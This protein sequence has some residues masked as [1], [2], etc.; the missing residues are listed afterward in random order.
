MEEKARRTPEAARTAQY[1][2][3]ENERKSTENPIIAKTATIADANDTTE[4][5]VKTKNP[6]TMVRSL[7]VSEYGASTPARSFEYAYCPAS[8]QPIHASDAEAASAKSFQSAKYGDKSSD[9][10]SQNGYAIAQ[11]TARRRMTTKLLKNVR[12]TGFAPSSTHEK[13]ARW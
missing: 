8:D 12:K 4:E 1:R 2:F 9:T 5:F 13:I 6:A 10:K 7:P 11:S 3:T